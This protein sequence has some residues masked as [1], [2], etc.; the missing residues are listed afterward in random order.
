MKPEEGSYDKLRPA[1]RSRHEGAH[2]LRLPPAWRC[3]QADRI[4]F[5]MADLPTR[6][7][8]TR[9]PRSATP[10]NESPPE[11]D[12]QCRR[13]ICTKCVSAW[14][15]SLQGGARTAFRIEWQSGRQCRVECIGVIDP[16][17]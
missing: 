7:E 2:D 8:P 12:W 3:L 11:L 10:A 14:P 9:D 6:D 5:L 17:E 4:T 13:A 15:R 16:V 1:S